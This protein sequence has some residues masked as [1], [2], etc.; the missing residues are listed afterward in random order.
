MER[1]KK[2][3][4]K[5]KKKKKKKENSERM[6]RA[7]FSYLKKDNPVQQKSFAYYIHTCT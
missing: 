7:S 3:K 1:K 6:Q 5:K 4:K 2:W